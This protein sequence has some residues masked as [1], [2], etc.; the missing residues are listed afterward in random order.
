M[1][2]YPSHTR[3]RHHHR[4]SDSYR[5]ELDQALVFRKVGKKLWIVE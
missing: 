4:A 2:P 5:A 3:E 1:A